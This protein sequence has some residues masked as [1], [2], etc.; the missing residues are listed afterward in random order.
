MMN[1]NY[2]LSD[3]ELLALCKCTSTNVVIF[4]QNVVDNSLVYLRSAL[5]GEAAPVLTSIQVG[6]QGRVRSHFER[7]VLTPRVPVHTQHTSNM[8]PLGNVAPDLSD[9][10]THSNASTSQRTYN[11]DEHQS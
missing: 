9:A 6:V 1:D 5:D 4:K 2:Y 7:V 10:F 3:V 8:D 11:K